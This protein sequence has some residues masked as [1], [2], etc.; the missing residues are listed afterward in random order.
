MSG[1]RSRLPYLSR[2]ILFL[3]LLP[4]FCSG[5]RLTA[6]EVVV[7]KEK[8][9]SLGPFL[10]IYED[11]T[12]LLSINDIISPKYAPLFKPQKK[13]RQAHGLTRNVLWIKVVLKNPDRFERQW[14]LEVGPASLNRVNLYIQQPNNAFQ[15]IEKGDRFPFSSREPAYIRHLFPLTFKPDQIQ[16]F[17]LEIASTDELAIY[18]KAFT[19]EAFVEDAGDLRFFL[20]FYFGLMTVMG[21]YN[22][23]IF[24]SVRDKSYFYYVVYIAGLVLYLFCFEGLAF[25]YFWPNNPI[26][27][28]RAAYFFGGWGIMAACAFSKSF[29][30]TH[31][32]A[33]RINL[34]LSGMIGLGALVSL[35]SFF[36]FT[37]F[38]Q[39]L[40]YS[41]LLC[42]T[43]I[44]MTA[45]FQSWRKGYRPAV[46]FLAAWTVLLAGLSMHALVIF[47]LI[48]S[49]PH[50]V[51]AIFYGSASE[52][53]LLSLGLASRI[54]ELKSA[55]NKAQ[56]N[57]RLA[58]QANALKDEFLATTSHELRTPLHGMIGLLES[59]VGGTSGQLPQKAKNHLQMVLN[60]GQRLA[61]LINDI[62]DFSKIEAGKMELE[63]SVFSL[64]DSLMGVRNL[65]IAIARKKNLELNVQID[66]NVPDAVMGDRGRL[67]QILLNLTGNALKFTEQG[68]VNIHVAMNGFSNQ[69]LVLKFEVKDTGIGIAPEKTSLLFKDFSQVDDSV[70]RMQVGTGLG[71][72][73]S[74]RLVEAMGGQIGVMSK[75]GIGSQFYFTAQFSPISESQLQED[76][77]CPVHSSSLTGN[78]QI[79][80]V[81]DN[82]VNRKLFSRLLEKRG[83][84]HRMAENGEQALEMLQEDRFHL[85]FMDC[86]M[87]L[88]DGFETTARIRNLEGRIARIPIIAL[89]AATVQGD[90]EKCLDAGMN[91]YLSKPLDTKRFY[92]LINA[93]LT[94]DSG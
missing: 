76:E 39:Y 52:A 94:N 1:T 6:S 73:I 63:E 22:L 3:S 40:G 53:I 67:R 46:Y 47:G 24:I 28:D 14:N 8:R 77:D 61:Y 7:L 19:P 29:L 20:G 62:L 45:G 2:T 87:P 51:N 55:S 82:S 78:G 12:G 26:W 58:E 33:T 11:E 64:N 56:R 85:V 18:L 89:T 9:Q 71:L 4:S 81:E 5:L 10:S 41:L 68:Q 31:I 79:L 59:V 91:D 69:K 15:I 37:V 34:A 80:V 16:T 44:I 60:T 38:A 17:Y 93:Y 35:T 32:H 50:F 84:R 83:Y 23:F 88:M 13:E 92:Q 42:M 48:K 74:K 30:R 36:G 75:P 54:N 49:S 27:N 90:R 66:R 57:M 43:V 25:Q 72:A 86:N 65:L 21:L 70:Q